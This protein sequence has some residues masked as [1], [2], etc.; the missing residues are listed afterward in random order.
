MNKNF[1]EKS[2]FSRLLREFFKKEKDSQDLMFFFGRCWLL[3]FAALGNN[4]LFVNIQIP[5]ENK[6]SIGYREKMQ[7]VLILP[8]Y[9]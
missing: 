2:W 8:M 6:L 4:D 9:F 3:A 5:Q 1:P 7:F